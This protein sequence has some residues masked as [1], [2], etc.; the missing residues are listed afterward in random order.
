MPRQQS[1]IFI[2]NRSSTGALAEQIARA[3][4]FRLEIAATIN[5]GLELLVERPFDVIVLDVQASAKSVLDCLRTIVHDDPEV[6][7]IVAV[8]A[9]DV[10][11]AVQALHHGAADVLVRPLSSQSLRRAIRS[12]LG[13]AVKEPAHSGL[14]N[15]QLLLEDN[16]VIVGQTEL[17]REVEHLIAK[18]APTDA[19]VLIC[20][21]SGTGKELVARAIHLQ[22][23]RRKAAFVVVDCGSLVENLFES[24][25]FGH[26]KGSFTGATVTKHG[27]FELADG[28]TIFLDEIGQIS[29]NL[30]GKMLRVLQEREITKV[31]SNQVVKVDV[32]VIAA[33]NTQ[34]QVAAAQGKFRRELFYRLHVVPILLPPLRER[35]ADIP[36]LARHFLEKYRLVRHKKVQDISAR[37]ME[38]L[39][40]YDWPGNVRELEHAI[41]RAVVLAEAPIIS[42]R[43]LTYFSLEEPA[44]EELPADGRLRTM[45]KMHI[46]RALARLGGHRAK[47]AEYL[48]IDRKTLRAKMVN[49]GLSD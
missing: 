42:P 10:P 20:G 36:L 8:P 14:R 34:L 15:N 41:E 11:S 25:L 17:M 30:Q 24:E 16:V 7:V 19:T 12:A 22:S 44:T 21:E 38:R 9:D 23:N 1:L 40:S 46:Q 35:K 5:K 3:D 13:T 6:K 49:Y 48:G 33:T 39:L 43:D 47:T 28:G 26:V 45:E 37:A 18:A 4:A 27:R 31:G 2:T 29:P 32:R